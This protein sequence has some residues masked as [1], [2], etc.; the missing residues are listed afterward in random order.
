MVKWDA[1][2]AKYGDKYV[3]APRLTPKIGILWNGKVAGVPRRD[4]LKVLPGNEFRKEAGVAL[5]SFYKVS[6]SWH[7]KGNDKYLAY[8]TADKNKAEH[9]GLV[10]AHQKHLKSG[11]IFHEDNVRSRFVFFLFKVAPLLHDDIKKAEAVLDEIGTCIR[12]LRFGKGSP[13][14]AVKP[15]RFPM[16]IQDISSSTRRR[17]GRRSPPQSSRTSR[18]RKRRTPPIQRLRRLMIRLNQLGLNQRPI[19][20]SATWLSTPSL[21]GLF[22]RSWWCSL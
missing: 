19:L 1:V 20:S 10:K 22:S 11:T 4:P 16:F 2:K 6:A 13:F 21:V 5:D 3:K 18:T 9:Q 14:V 8:A 17:E 7:L 12:D 15:D